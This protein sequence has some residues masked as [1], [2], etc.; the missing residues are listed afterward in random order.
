MRVFREHMLAGGHDVGGDETVDPTH[1]RDMRIRTVTI[2][3]PDADRPYVRNGEP[4]T[5]RIAYDALRPVDDA[6]FVFSLH[7]NDGHIV[8]GQNTWGLG[9]GLP[10]LDGPG[11]VAFSIP[12]VSLLEGSYPLTVGV[13]R[14]EG[15]VVFDW[16]EQQ[17]HLDVVNAEGK[18]AW[19]V[20]DLPVVA[21]LSRLG[22]R[23]R[24]G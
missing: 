13:H 3:Y 10:V 6:V 4:V 2:E 9:H 1:G 21:D 20:V 8:F 12:S 23:V 11:E 16:R 7:G 22:T 15:G 19:G 17:S 14:R 5:I 18:H 24:A